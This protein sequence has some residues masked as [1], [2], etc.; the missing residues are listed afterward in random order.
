MA[1]LTTSVATSWSGL[2]AAELWYLWDQTK[3]NIC[4]MCLDIVLCYI[5]KLSEGFRLPFFR[6]MAISLGQV[7]KYCSWTIKVFS[8]S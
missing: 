1:G 2:G 5:P 7:L 3:D 4:G 8:P 6:C